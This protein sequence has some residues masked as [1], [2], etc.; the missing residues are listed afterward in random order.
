MRKLTLLLLFGVSSFLSLTHQAQA[1]T[2]TYYVDGE[3]LYEECTSERAT[4]EVFC[5]SYIMAIA[6]ALDGQRHSNSV[7]A[8]IPAQ[9]NSTTLR[10]VVL[11]FLRERPQWRHWS[12]YE[13][14]M[15][16]L[17]TAYCGQ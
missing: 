2:R 14:V 6:D 11:N 10:D 16:S 7:E 5:L 17:I 3:R 12:A 4:G 8:C 9:V 1:Q 15:L 13:L